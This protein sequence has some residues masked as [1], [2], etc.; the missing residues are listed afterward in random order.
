MAQKMLTGAVLSMSFNSIDRLLEP[1]KVPE[2]TSMDLPDRAER[3][4][5]VRTRVHWPVRF[6]RDA[7]E[8]VTTN[9]SSDGFYCQSR[10]S[11]VTG[12]VV[13]CTLKVPTHQPNSTD[14]TLAMK[15]RVQIVRV[16][17]PDEEGY[18][19]IGCRLVDYMLQNGAHP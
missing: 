13:V 11:F 4:R 7:S 16:M 6:D 15:C 14:D 8:T 9:L 1:F 18:Y 5:R 12:E 17:G 2:T 10:V 19:G 3:R